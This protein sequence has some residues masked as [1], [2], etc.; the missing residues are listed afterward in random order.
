MSLQLEPVWSWI[1]AAG[2]LI[3]VLAVI[4]MAYPRQIRHLPAAR[5]KL[6]AGL[7]LSVA[8]LLFLLMLRPSLI[9]QSQDESGATV[10]VLLDYS[11]SMKTEDAAGGATRRQELVALMDK[12]APFLKTI[13]EKTEVRLRNFSDQVTATASAGPEADGTMTALGRIMELSA[14]EMGKGRV[15]A[16]LLLSDGRQA[17]SGKLDIDPL[18]IARRYG[19][20]QRPIYSLGFGSTQAAS[21]SLDLALQDLDLARDVF[22]GNVLPIRVRLKSTGAQGQQARVKVS[23]ENR[24]GLVEGKSGPLE[25]VPTTDASR[26]LSIVSI[27][28]PTDDQQVTLQIVP[29]QAGEL[30][31][32]VEAEPLPGEARQTNNRVE[33]IIRVRRGGIRVACFDIIRSEQKW[34]RKINDSSRIQLDFHPIRSKEF[35]D[36]NQIPDRYFQPGNYDAFI[37]GDVP[38]S[39][40]RPDQILNMARCCNQGAGLMM[41]GGRQNF[42]QGGW[43]QTPL[44]SLLPVELPLVN[45]QLTQPQKMLPSRDGLGHFVMQ[46]AAPEQ[47]RSRWDQ[48]PPLSGANALVLKNNSL[49]QVLA[50]SADGIPLLIG[51]G[52][53]RGRVLA[54]AGDTTWQWTMQ[55]FEEEHARFW[56][57][58]IFWL[59]RKETDDS[60]SVWIQ[61]NPRDLGTGMPTELS[62]GARDAQGQ[63]LPDISFEVEVTD[64]T[65]KVLPLVPQAASGMS[66]AEFKDTLEPGDYW[67]R[68]RATRAGQMFGNIG[69]TRFHVIARDPEL[70]DPSADFAMLRE[71][72]HA[73]G[74]EFLTEQQLLERLKS[75][76]NAGLPGLSLKRQERITLWDNWGT[77]LLIITIMGCEWALRRKSGLA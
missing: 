28:S 38:A 57:Q 30:K 15:P 72:S 48:L 7:R 19:R 25:P 61:A 47:N 66:L 16:V 21:A 63:P 71:I 60:Q 34:L 51:Q 53:G 64:P 68:V 24:I 5:R 69:V 76:A 41:I 45:Q 9:I 36:R 56:R 11:R 46:I 67:A 58:I 14:E 65:G 32:V 12:A 6:L 29:E 13:A 62:F 74:G 73:S 59:T 33:T 10:Y 31:L 17:A 2:V 20:L 35:N 52:T 40:F 39:A 18:T 26:P 23:L 77:L 75:W 27:T 37:L 44:A 42:G 54:F 43:A 50:V 22:Q 1:F 3:A 8:L 49:A 4:R 70:D 55:G